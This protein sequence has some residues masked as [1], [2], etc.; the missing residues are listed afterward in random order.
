MKT[1]KV[2]CRLVLEF[3]LGNASQLLQTP[4]GASFFI[5]TRWNRNGPPTDTCTNHVPPRI[6][7]PLYSCPESCLTQFAQLHLIPIKKFG[8]FYYYTNSH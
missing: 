5:S 3:V 7:H 4:V 2:S 1:E 8:S 6:S